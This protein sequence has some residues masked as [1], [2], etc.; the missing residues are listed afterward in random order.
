MPIKLQQR[1]R[2]ITFSEAWNDLPS[3]HVRFCV[4]NFADEVIK[5]A[6]SKD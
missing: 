3:I 6:P 2:E 4:K 5:N 1:V